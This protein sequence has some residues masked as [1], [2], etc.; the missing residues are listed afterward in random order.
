MGVDSLIA[1]RPVKRRKPPHHKL[2]RLARPA[3]FVLGLEWSAGGVSQAF[4]QPR[5]K[6]QAVPSPF[7]AADTSV[8]VVPAAYTRQDAAVL[9][10]RLEMLRRGTYESTPDVELRLRKALNASFLSLSAGG[11]FC[12]TPEITYDADSAVVTVSVR[13]MGEKGLTIQCKVGKSDRYVGQNAFG[14][15]ANVLRRRYLEF[16]IV[17]S[18]REEFSALR[19]LDTTVHLPMDR[20]SASVTFP[21]LR[22]LLVFEPS[23]SPEGV[24]AQRDIDGDAATISLPIAVETQVRTIYAR[25]AFLWIYDRVSGEVMRK[26][27]LF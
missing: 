20:A 22:S 18:N 2:S 9:F 21:R 12:A 17:P 6:A 11:T 8:T 10:H 15:R 13:G 26:V 5:P 19:S 14:V 3:L 4:A 7:V 25:R 1:R 16:R 23:M 24:V 27:R